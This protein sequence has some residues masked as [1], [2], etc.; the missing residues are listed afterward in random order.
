MY[1]SIF[2]AG[3][4]LVESRFAGMPH[5]GQSQV[6]GTCAS[7]AKAGFVSIDRDL[8]DAA[9]S[10]GAGEWQ[11]FRYVAAPLAARALG[12]GFV[13]GFARALGEFGA[14]LM[15]AGAIPG[16]TLTLPTAI[17]LAVESGND[18]MAWSWCAAIAGIG[19]SLLLA[20]R[21]WTSGKVER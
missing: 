7:A 12:A 1:G 2:G 13:L 16:R 6:A 9:R 17:Y 3:G 19:F 21:A 10:I 20:A 14:T 11:L 15:F 5:R 18:A 8:T 4:G